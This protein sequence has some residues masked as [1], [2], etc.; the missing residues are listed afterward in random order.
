MLTCEGYAT[1]MFEPKENPGYEKLAQ[2]AAGTIE[3][4]FQNEWYQASSDA[5]PE[6]V[7]EVGERVEEVGEKVEEVG[8]HDKV[9]Q[10]DESHR[11]GDVLPSGV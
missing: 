7:E 2:D 11:V 6:K 9:E 8:E 4:W 5:E 3:K 1:D 10:G